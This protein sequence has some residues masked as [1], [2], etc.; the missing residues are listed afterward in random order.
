MPSGAW[1]PF[2]WTRGVTHAENAEPRRRA[3][4]SPVPEVILNLND[5]P[6]A[7]RGIGRIGAA[8]GREDRTPAPTEVGAC[9]ERR[10]PCQA[11]TLAG[12]CWAWGGSLRFGVLAGWRDRACGNDGRS[13]C[14][15]E[16]SRRRRVPSTALIRDSQNAKFEAI[17]F[18]VNRRSL[19]ERPRPGVSLRCQR[20]SSDRIHDVQQ[21]GA[22]P[23][24][25][26]RAVA[27]DAEAII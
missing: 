26:R 9:F 3:T 1:A 22:V 19:Q 25:A 13:P 18:C 8:A 4:H 2:R 14:P 21:R 23:P 17:A 7:Q 16:I 11:V 12:R 5:G 27:F 20:T 6:H 15:A 24:P 10:T